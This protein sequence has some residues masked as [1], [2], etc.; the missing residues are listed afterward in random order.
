[1]ETLIEVHVGE[2]FDYVSD[3]P[4]A[5]LNIFGMQD[6]LPYDFIKDMSNKT[7]SSCLF[8]RDSGHESILA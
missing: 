6:T 2:F 4:S 1:P 5:D 7:S 3:A 8:V